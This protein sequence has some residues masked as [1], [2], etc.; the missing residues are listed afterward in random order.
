MLLYPTFFSTAAVGEQPVLSHRLLAVCMMAGCA[1]RLRDAC[2]AVVRMGGNRVRVS[3]V[4]RD[5]MR[6][7]SLWE[8]V[9]L[10]GLLVCLRAIWVMTSS[11]GR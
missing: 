11:L 8:V 6:H 7:G 4:D 9:G 1:P 10:V 2:G 5:V 3:P